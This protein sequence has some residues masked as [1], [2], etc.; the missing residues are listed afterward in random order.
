MATVNF[1]VLGAAVYPLRRVPQLQTSTDW[2]L[3]YR[4]IRDYLACNKL[5]E[6]QD[7]PVGQHTPIVRPETMTLAREAII[8]TCGDYARNKISQLTD[9]ATILGVLEREFKSNSSMVSMCVFREFDGL[10]STSF[11]NVKEYALEF[12][13]LLFELS[14]MGSIIPQDQ[15]YLLNK[16]LL[17]LDESFDYFR[18]F[19]LNSYSP[20]QEPGR[21]MVDLE[22]TIRLAMADEQTRR[23]Q[24]RVSAPVPQPVA[25]TSDKRIVEMEYC[26]YCK[27]LGH[28]RQ[29][30]R[31]L[32][33]KLRAALINNGRYKGKAKAA[34]RPSN[35]NSRINKTRC[36]KQSKLRGRIKREIDA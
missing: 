11:R 35:G 4:R 15:A 34:L 7:Q 30:C 29:A 21:Q 22:E 16:F 33:R 3:W 28:T 25:A 6:F 24:S 27:R 8:S 19:F 5:A 20:I 36:G 1:S 12:K 10:R 9:V 2:H 14:D 26:N 13:R 32:R 31:V 17:G 23:R 18:E